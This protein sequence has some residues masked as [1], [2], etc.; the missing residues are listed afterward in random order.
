MTATDMD[1]DDFI[2]S[3]WNDHADQPVAVAR[4]AAA[5]LDRPRDAAQAAALARLLTHVYGE[6]L[7]EWQHGAAIL[8]RLGE[9]PAA[10]DHATQALLARSSAALRHAGGEPGVLDALNT[11]D[12]AFVLA[13][14]AGALAGRNDWDRV[15][16]EYAQALDIADAGLSERSPAARALAVAGNNIAFALEQKPDRDAGLTA[17]MIVAAQGALT[18]WRK[19]GTWL[20]EERAHYRLAN[21]LLQAGRDDEALASAHECESICSAKDAPPLEHF[22]AQAILA[23]VARA[24]RRD[25]DFAH[26]REQATRHFEALSEDDRGWCRA[27]LDRLGAAPA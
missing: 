2:A 12:R 11:D 20:E 15:A 14:A 8:V 17:A 22:F 3:A 9:Q 18:Y 21:S 4:R 6:H 13:T 1:F 27:E 7:G 5:A 23:S 24:Q 19:A 25:A 10:A 26:A 16:R